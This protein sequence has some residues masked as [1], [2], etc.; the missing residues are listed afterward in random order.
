MKKI[1]LCFLLACTALVSRA[2]EFP[3][4]GFHID[5]RTQVMTLDAMKDF[6]EELAGF[7]INTLIVEWE[8]TFPY[9]K[10]AV[11]SNPQAFTPQEVTEFVNHCS[12]LGIDVIPL[13]QCFGHVEYILRHERYNS[14]KETYELEI[15]QICPQK[16]GVV[17]LFADIFDK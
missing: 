1:V 9:D 10:H 8:A 5:F 14:F 4:R 2:A 13:Q 16:K 3:V 6:A 12:S 17:E 15:S 7:G 11:I